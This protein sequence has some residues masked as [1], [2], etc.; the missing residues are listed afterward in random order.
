[1]GNVYVTIDTSGSLVS[2]RNAL[3]PADQGA[4]AADAC[5]ATPI[6]PAARHRTTATRTGTNLIRRPPVQPPGTNTA[7][8]MQRRRELGPLM[9]RLFAVA[10]SCLGASA[11][12]FRCCADARSSDSAAASLAQGRGVSGAVASDGGAARGC[13][14][15]DAQ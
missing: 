14:R 2:G 15:G 9:A 1:M 5:D 3:A 13:G 12:C 8:R 4:S 10:V 11:Q 6:D 7:R